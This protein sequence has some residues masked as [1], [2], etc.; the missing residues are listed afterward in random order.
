MNLTYLRSLFSAARN[1]FVMA[2]LFFPML[3]VGQK[4]VRLTSYVNPLL[5]TTV[6]TDSSLLGYNP[7]WR[8]WNGLTGPGATVPHGMVQVVPVTTYGSGSG[9]EYEINTIKAIAQTSGNH[10]GDLNIPVMPLEGADFTADDFASAYSHSTEVARPG[11]YEVM[12]ERY[13]IKAQLT[14]TKRAA[15][16]KYTYTG[17]QAK[18]LAFDLVR[19]GGG[20]STWELSQ[21]GDYALTGRQGN[22]YFYA[23]V[24]HKIKSI[25]AYKRNPNQPEVPRSGQGA[26]GQRK[27]TGNLDVMV[28][29]LENSNRP[30]ELKIALSRVSPEGAKAN[31]DAEIAN[32][33]FDQVYSEA[34]KTWEQLLGKIKV[35]GGTEKQKSMF[36]SCLYRQFCYPSVTSDA[37]GKTGGRIQSNPGFETYA[38]P[39]LWDV[40]RTQ[41]PVLDL[42]EPDVSNNV[43]KS[44]I[45]NGE[46]SGFLPTS[47]H[48]DF[49]S[50]YIAG[51]YARGIRDYDVKEAYRLMLNNANTP[52]GEGVKGPRPHNGQYLKLGY[53]PE[54]DIKN[55]TT[56]TV[57]TA[58]TTKTLEFAYS[59]YSIAQLG[60]AL[61]DNDTYNIMMKRSQNYRNVFD[62]QTGFMRGRLADGKWVSP[63]DPGYPYYEFMYREANAWQASFF[64]PQD[65]K[66]L[67]SLYQ[68]PRDFELKID[69]LFSVPWGGYAKDN[70]SVFLGQF[71]MGNQP[72]FSYPYLYYFVNKP[73]KSQAILNKLMSDCFG[74]GA[75]GLALAGMDDYGSLTGWYVLNAMGIYPYSP[76]D[77]EYIVSVPIFDKVEMQLGNGKVFTINKREKGKHIS[78]ITIAGAPLNGWF[79]SYADIA[80]G[81]QLDVFTK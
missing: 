40:F 46:R 2:L 18:K 7:P 57:S 27:L 76:A 44:M 6:L 73:E 38:S 8:T 47:F 75:E 11:Y 12:L 54:A 81:K 56:E 1:I 48:G 32:K 5:G 28:I 65:T 49:A 37:D 42:I 33:D 68:S 17:G 63:F 58:G 4:Q 50:T 80:K 31:Y 53:L 36:Y 24:N 22:L 35:T 39:A 14:A 10:W 64:V 52:T 25:D 20:S 26:G 51:A 16:H 72:D 21:A 59:D 19:A 77:P 29:S 41:L 79:V 74:M 71:C 61:G 13:K 62:A 23:V 45:L 15:Y 60:K 66:G 43:I 69:S 3:S 67:I 78:K 34:D 30:L 55:P 9:Y 70:L